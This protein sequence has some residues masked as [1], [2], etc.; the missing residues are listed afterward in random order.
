MVADALAAL[1]AQG[2]PTYCTAISWAEIY[3]GLRAG[4]EAPTEAFFE[5]RGE[6]LLDAVAGRRAGQYLARHRAS[7]GVEIADA[8]VAAAA[9]TA[10][11][12][13][14]TRNRRHYSMSDLS[15]Y[16]PEVS[17]SPPE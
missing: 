10:G 13:L 11:L 15:F 7:H 1:E 6:V 14:W 2:T 12:Q 16:E 9:V 8:L 3:A 5:A 4:E 17:G